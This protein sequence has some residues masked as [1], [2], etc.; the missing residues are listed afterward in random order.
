MNFIVAVDQNYA[1][2]YKNQLLF[3]LKQDLQYFKQTTI[4][5]VVIMGD[6]TFYSL[7]G[8]KAL[9]NRTNIVLTLN[10][11]FNEPD[12]I[13]AHNFK[14]LAE[15]IKDYDPDD[16]FVT[17]GASVYT[18]LI[19]YCK[20]GYITKIKGSKEADRYLPNLDL[21]DNWDLV[22]ISPTQEEDGVQFNFCIYENDSPKPFVFQ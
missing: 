9:K 13:V 8:S 18:Q 20:K 5:K 19:P 7:P 15:I 22:S 11:D 16:G 6:T 10:P 2:G 14:E 1:I 12:T 21:M 17:G 3:S 4:N